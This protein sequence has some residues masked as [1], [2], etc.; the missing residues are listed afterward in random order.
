M[1]C[2]NSKADLKRFIRSA[3][4]KN[5]KTKKETSRTKPEYFD[6]HAAGKP[7]NIINI[8]TNKNDDRKIRLKDIEKDILNIVKEGH[9]I[10][11][12]HT[13]SMW[14][15][16]KG[17]F[18][19]NPDDMTIFHIGENEKALNDEITS[20]NVI[21]AGLA[22]Q[23][24][25]GSFKSTLDLM[26]KNNLT[27]NQKEELYA[28]GDILPGISAT[29]MATAIGM[30]IMYSQ[31]M[32]Y[33]PKKSI[34]NKELAQFEVNEAYARVGMK[35]LELLE[36]RDFV[37]IEKPGTGKAEPKV[38]N[39][40]YRTP[41]SKNYMGGSKVV[42]GT[43]IRL[44]LEKLI[45]KNQ[46]DLTNR[47]RLLLEKYFAKQTSFA[48]SKYIESK[49]P[50][51]GAN[52]HGSTYLRRLVVPSNVLGPSTEPIKNDHKNDDVKLS[53]N[54]KKLLD[55]KEKGPLFIPNDI[56]E[57]MDVIYDEMVKNDS[58]PEEALE[59]L[60]F[61]Y[62]SL[63]GFGDM[64]ESTAATR[65][66]AFGKTLS[67]T[68]P[69]SQFMDNYMMYKRLPIH[70]REEIKRN[71]RAHYMNTFLNPQTDK[72]FSRYV[73]QIDEYSIPAVE[74][75]KITDVFTHMLHGIADQ[76]GVSENEILNLGE[77]KALDRLVT[78]YAAY[79][80][81][82]T[83]KGRLSFVSKALGSDNVLD[84]DVWQK[85]DSIKAIY[86]VRKAFESGSNDNVKFTGTFM[87]KP[88]GTASGAV[89]MSMQMLGLDEENKGLFHALG[90]YSDESGKNP[91]EPLRDAYGVMEAGI[92]KYMESQKE[93]AAEDRE[94]TYKTIKH[95]LDNKLFGSTLAKALR[96]MAKDPSMVI[97]YAQGEASAIQTMGEAFTER[98]YGELEK[99]PQNEAN[100]E[101]IM[102][103]LKEE[104]PELHKAITNDY[105][106]QR[107]RVKRNLG[108]I[109]KSE[110]YSKAVMNTIQNTMESNVANRFFKIVHEEYINPYIK[111]HR[112]ITNNIF[113]LIEQANEK[114][115]QRVTLVT[116]ERFFDAVREDMGGTFDIDK[117][118]VKKYYSD[119]FMDTVKDKRSD[120]RYKA[121]GLP[122]MKLFETVSNM[123]D[124]NTV[125]K[126]EYLHKINA[127]VNVVHSIDF[128]I[129]N[130]AHR[131]TMEDIKKTDPE[132][133]DNYG[134]VSIH[135]AISAHP[136]YSMIYEGHYQK[137]ARDINA[138]YDI[139]SMMIDILKNM[140]GYKQNQD[141]FK[142]V[143]KLNDDVLDT[144]SKKA[145]R[146]K[147]MN[148]ST[149]KVFGFEPKK[150]KMPIIGSKMFTNEQFFDETGNIKLQSPD[151]TGSRAKTKTTNTV[152]ETLNNLAK[153]SDI[154]KDFVEEY[155]TNK[156][157]WSDSSN[158]NVKSNKIY[159]DQDGSLNKESLQ[160]IA[161]HEI[162]HF[163]TVAYL[164]EHK[165]DKDVDLMYKTIEGLKKTKS[166]IS[167]RLS[168]RANR[169][170]NHMTDN[171]SD[172]QNVAELVAIAQTEPAYMQEILK[173]AGSKSLYD[174]ISE[175]ID[176]VLQWGAEKINTDNV[177][178]NDMQAVLN[179]VG[180]INTKGK[181][182]N[183]TNKAPLAR[184]KAADSIEGNKVY[185]PDIN[186]KQN[187][188]T[189][190]D[191][192]DYSKNAETDYVTM[193]PV[194]RYITDINGLVA[195]ILFERLG[196]EAES[197]AKQGA[198]QVDEY[199]TE[200]S[201]AYRRT[202]DMSLKFWNH[203]EMDA[204][205]MYLNPS[206]Y[207]KGD[208]RAKMQDFAVASMKADQ[209]HNKMTTSE[210]RNLD[211]KMK[212]L[213]K[214]EVEKLNDVFALA[215]VFQ[216]VKHGSLMQDIA[217]GRKTINEAI[218]ELEQGLDK[219]N[220]KAAQDFANL[221]IDGEA[222]GDYYNT[223][224]A[225]I[226][227]D[228]LAKVEQLSVLYSFKKV[229]GSQSLIRKIYK[230]KRSLYDDL[231]EFSLALEANTEK[232]YNEGGMS[233]NYEDARRYRG[234]M[235]HDY[236]DTNMQIRAFSREDM[237]DSNF[238]AD[239]WQVLVP[240]GEANGY[241]IMYN[242]SDTSQYQEG[243]GANVG[244][245]SSD[246]IMP[247]GF[248]PTKTM[249]GF[250]KFGNGKNA[251]YKY[252]IPTKLKKEKLGLITNPAHTIIRSFAHIE[253]V[254]GTN[255]I[256]EEMLNSSV[257]M[258]VNTNDKNDIQKLKKHAKERDENEPW[259]VQLSDPA[260]YINLPKEIKQR[261]SLVDKNIKLSNVGGFQHKITMVRNDVKPWLVGYK[262]AAPFEHTPVLKDVFN[263]ILKAISLMKIHM[264]I[265]NPAKVTLDLISTTT[266]LV[267]NGVSPL[268]IAK[269]WKKNI[270]LMSSMAKLREKQVVLTLRASS[271]NKQA[272]AGL[273][274]VEKQLADHP[275]MGHIN[276]GVMQSLTTDII[277]RD[278]DT[279]TGLQR[280][281]EKVI[282][283]LTHDE[284]GVPNG[285]HEA[286]M[287]FAGAGVN[288]EDLMAH[289][290]H[291]ADKI[292]TLK[293]M[294]E[295]LGH[296]GERI[297]KIKSDK[298]VAKY[299]SEYFASPSSTLTKVGSVMT[300][301]P[302]AMSRI[303]YR[304][305]LI[306]QTGKKESQLSDKEIAKIN[307]EVSDFMP[308]Y[309]FHPPMVLDATGRWFILPFVSW[310]SR[311]QRT[312]LHL[313]K[314]RPLTFLAPAI[315]LEAMGYDVGNNDMHIIG[316]N[317]FSRNEY[318]NNVFDDVFSM[319]TLL[320]VNILNF[321]ILK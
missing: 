30:E 80:E 318:I 132:F 287:K 292:E 150:I 96:N 142:Q 243:F 319:E 60:G 53:E 303:I 316:S 254:R 281:I 44:N 207:L 232:A 117:F 136:K 176:K 107:G 141:S 314:K 22:F 166:R 240:P 155:G 39:N 272:E 25:I 320:P 98:I 51:I 279:I 63:L 16:L 163:N 161:E 115:S 156:V 264:I 214:K 175:F 49:Y 283:K 14:K 215:P 9:D 133:L 112:R 233:N 68:N 179:A 236:Y 235:I 226:R 123:K 173:A 3:K 294:A 278:Y 38:I 197:L 251:R 78:K 162:V 127:I 10:A 245:K 263:V 95:V 47:D 170:L 146:L 194:S 148:T 304:D 259:F 75:G 151:N 289:M 167:K 306:A 296:M 114:H 249:N 185:A 55:E 310:S 169:L 82:S 218:T 244:Y 204:I 101:F 253:K 268:T 321:N 128:A 72:F 100:T 199:L 221:Y 248:K 196:T 286:I 183:K 230:E 184:T 182:F 191:A 198:K 293:P 187:K 299:L 222:T 188:K 106:N 242:D 42:E 164:E 91:A 5:V 134:T 40:K 305:H 160:R 64:K 103:L 210:T 246:V 209:M 312:L 260:E 223:K 280:D 24:V 140:E 216:L 291:A 274:K 231:V 37:S 195:D 152:K 124:N 172:L 29:G 131:R 67:K 11:R 275:L 267:S 247:K 17:M 41:T 126:F 76:A 8:F 307:V 118:D 157:N 224:Q 311:V 276:A 145:E 99:N 174:K 52:T 89:I 70:L 27:E 262:R 313:S 116:P 28:Y 239:E 193:D 85:Y 208:Q 285:F 120:G 26:E 159:I 74:N 238:N 295:E 180:S 13:P 73:M 189:L 153:D 111:N 192:L 154:V 229:D 129:L 138:V 66:S 1:G 212:G 119:E 228:K 181:A 46:D 59:S 4:S 125:A 7:T 62:R 43:V 65:D 220:I 237:L 45:G 225:K 158:Y 12:E 48:D 15:K 171:E 97:L 217:S 261:Y 149:H 87:P 108:S 290:A 308:D 34:E 227:G 190:K 298:D 86:Q 57:M 147:E 257:R 284:N 256:R 213:D 92:T 6:T 211:N 32:A 56:E 23:H 250:V 315:L 77:N 273:K 88:D 122:L 282:N 317:I 270:Q 35:A 50:Q 252:V 71:G 206:Y 201:S 69:V 143:N 20:L 234:N 205:K 177:Y 200:H 109:A 18:N 202:K 266:L 258:F 144:A 297:A 93:V 81:S 288:I 255:L 186:R 121:N 219:T 139:H 135:D 271:G 33:A 2:I 302:D 94:Y 301:Y 165:N 300:T 54:G 36:Q 113:D 19:M 58:T 265:V 84:G 31:N 168:P 309:A 137:A 277:T 203:P 130:E 104:D 241:T 269:G 178:K 110:K 61:N 90:L 79:L 83:P 102:D 105:K 21:Q